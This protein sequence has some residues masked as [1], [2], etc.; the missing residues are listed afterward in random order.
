[1]NIKGT[2]TYRKIVNQGYTPV[3]YKTNQ[4]SIAAF[5][6]AKGRKWMKVGLTDGRVKRVR[7]TE[8]KYMTAWT[9]KSGRVA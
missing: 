4:G 3:W 7:M 8:E 1:M 9:N 5:I 2:I 6:I